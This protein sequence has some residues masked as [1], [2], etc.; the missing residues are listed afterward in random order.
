MFPAN[1]F[2]ET[3]QIFRLN[4][5]QLLTKAEY[6]RS[7]RYFYGKT[8]W[9]RPDGI[10]TLPGY[11]LKETNQFDIDQADMPDDAIDKAIRASILKF[12]DVLTG[13]EKV[14]ERRRK[15]QARLRQ[16]TLKNYSHRC[17]LCDVSDDAFLVESQYSQVG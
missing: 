3:F 9:A 12:S 5:Y 13:D 10:S 14:L 1:S 4:N 16:L 7:R 11:V 2:R 15:G 17:G 8:D 6:Q